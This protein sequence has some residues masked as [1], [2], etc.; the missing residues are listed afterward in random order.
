MTDEHE[1]DLVGE[2]LAHYRVDAKLGQGG[3]GVVYRAEDTRLGRPVALKVLPAHVA[4]DP[5][6]RARFVREARSAAA[7]NHPSIAT[8]HDVGEDRGRVYIAMELVEGSTLRARIKRGVL[9]AG[10]AARIARQIAAKRVIRWT[11]FIFCGSKH[12]RERREVSG[13]MWMARCG[14]CP[15]VP[16]KVFAKARPFCPHSP[17]PPART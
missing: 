1:D 16:P 15:G 13:K 8:V 11:S 3:M 12:G 9:D 14:A 6:R 10:E 7:V 5:D 17:T 4:D 2:T